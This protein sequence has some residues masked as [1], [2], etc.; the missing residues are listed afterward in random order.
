MISFRTTNVY[1]TST[2]LSHSPKKTNESFEL[3]SSQFCF[4]RLKLFAFG[5]WNFRISIVCCIFDHKLWWNQSMNKSTHTHNEGKTVAHSY[6]ILLM[7]WTPFHMVA[8]L[9][10]CWRQSD[11]VQNIT[12]TCQW[13]WNNNRCLVSQHFFKYEYTV[14]LKLFFNVYNEQFQLEWI[15]FERTFKFHL[16]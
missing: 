7:Y 3:I 1:I 11:S 6:C 14:E 12:T 8:H 4:I 9:H 10:L 13:N 16:I 15:P 2:T 5:F